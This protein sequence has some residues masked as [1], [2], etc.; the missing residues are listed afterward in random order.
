MEDNRLNPHQAAAQKAVASFLVS[1][2]PRLSDPSKSVAATA[3]MAQACLPPF[4]LQMARWNDEGVSNTARVDAVINHVTS[5]VGSFLRTE[6]LCHSTT[7]AF[8][9]ALND[10]LF[11]T[12]VHYVEGTSPRDS[13]QINEKVEGLGHA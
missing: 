8:Q 9:R 5:I 3:H 13:L 4:I 6:D 2:A 11:R 1:V 10:A 7:H 12:L